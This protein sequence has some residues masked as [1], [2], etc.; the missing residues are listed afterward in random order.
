[1]GQIREA[2]PKERE[3]DLQ[4]GIDMNA[5]RNARE[6]ARR[7]IS[8]ETI[9]ALASA[10]S[11]TRGQSYFDDGAVSD[12]LQRGDRLTAEV[13]GSEFEPY[14]VSIRMHGDGVADAHCTCRYDWGGYCKHIVAVLLKFSDEK[15][16]LIE[17]KPVAEL[18]AELDQTRLIELLAKRTESDPELVTWIE[19]EL[20]TAIPARLPHR[21]DAGRRRTPVDPAPVREQA[22]VLLAGRNR[23]GRYWDGYRSSGDIEELQRL[24]EKAVPFLEVGDGANALRILEPIGEAFVD[25]WIDHSYG[26]DEHLY[27]LFADLGRL[28]AEAALMSELAAKE[29][30]ALAETLEEWQGRLEEYG[31]DEGFHVAIRALQRGWDDPGLVAVMAGK[32]RSWP[33]SG[34]DDWLEGHLR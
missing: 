14:Q 32:S 23:R 34:T 2:G 30:D 7:R 25:D 12:L 20:A 28:M 26:S 5:A 18:L 13:E 11:F 17:R 4:I 3:P 29:R 31:V 22:R 9:R 1:M 33:P 21:P 27:E 19:A 10:E 24:V 15:T 16:P 6:V 8:K